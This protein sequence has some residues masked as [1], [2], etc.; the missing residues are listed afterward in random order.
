MAA[1]GAL[2]DGSRAARRAPERLRTPRHQILR[3]G[4]RGRG[5][6]K[7]KRAGGKPV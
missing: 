1:E 3:K 6:T 2:P 4:E 5:Q 7:K